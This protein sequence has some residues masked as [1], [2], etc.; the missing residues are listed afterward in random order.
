[1]PVVD[2]L[3][4]IGRQIN[5]GRRV[6]MH[7][8]RA[9][10]VELSKVKIILDPP[11]AGA[12]SPSVAISVRGAL[13]AVR[14]LAVEH[15]AV[16]RGHKHSTGTSEV[17]IW[18]RMRSKSDVDDPPPHQSGQQSTLGMGSPGALHTLQNTGQAHLETTAV[19]SVDQ[20]LH[21]SAATAP[22]AV[23]AQVEVTVPTCW[24]FKNGFCRHGE[25]CWYRHV[26]RHHSPRDSAVGPATSV[27]PLPVVRAPRWQ[28][29]KNKPTLATP[30][31]VPAS[32]ASARSPSLASAASSSA[33]AVV[34]P[35][36]VSVAKSSR[37]AAAIKQD[38]ALL[39]ADAAERSLSDAR[40]YLE[41]VHADPFPKPSAVSAAT[42]SVRT[43]EDELNKAK[44]DLAAANAAAEETELRYQVG[45]LARAK[46]SL[47]R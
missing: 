4:W 17:A 33:A 7:I 10:N 19:G 36:Q 13:A 35:E 22:S 1:M 23:A 9:Q 40:E 5:A 44:E 20:Q 31:V 27:A 29:D 42:Q 30:S 38:A 26:G 28:D 43:A 41:A 24:H 14:Q 18:I 32:E 8:G 12:I 39:V 16:D 46:V 6:H 21:R 2:R 25:S 34:T 3:D 11:S 47:P 15:V 37:D 45:I